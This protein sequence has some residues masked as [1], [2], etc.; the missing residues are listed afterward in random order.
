MTSG[1]PE[2]WITITSWSC[3][4]Y[5]TKREEATV[6]WLSKPWPI[7]FYPSPTAWH[8]AG[9]LKGEAFLEFQYSPTLPRPFVLLIPFYL[10]LW[11]LCSPKLQHSKTLLVT[12]N[13][14]CL[15]SC[16]LSVFHTGWAGGS[17][18]NP[19]L[20]VMVPGLP[21]GSTSFDS[22][23]K[24][25]LH[26]AQPVTRRLD[27]QWWGVFIV[28]FSCNHIDLWACLWRFFL[29]CLIDMRRHTLSVGHTVMWAR[30]IS[31]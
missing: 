27:S 28:G 14:P 25:V 16:S 22:S 23:L 4:N 30:V 5:H 1:A 3:S 31:E 2:T 11:H 15:S 9:I 6:P 17:L 19:E 29:R 20:Y 18:T 26:R 8:P 10:G 21:Q 12:P 7:F 24:S 13:A